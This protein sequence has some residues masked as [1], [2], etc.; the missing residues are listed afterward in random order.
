MNMVYL[1]AWIGLICSA[2]ETPVAKEPT[3]SYGNAQVTA[4][5]RIDES[6][7]LYCDIK[8]FPPII[9]QDMPVKI[10]GLQTSTSVEQNHKIQAFLNLLLLKKTETPQHILLKHLQRG[11]QFC[12]LADIEIDGEDIC[13]LLIDHGLAQRIIAVSAGNTSPQP[14]SP[15]ATRL[16]VERAK[17]HTFVASKTSKIFHRIGC[18]HAKRINSERAVY[19]SSRQEAVQAGRQP[20]KI[21]NP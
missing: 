17:K 7:I 2:S 14:S 16:A 21:C 18:S 19:F 13:D 1:F 8:D 11:D 3:A 20:C 10:N 6:C 4:V 15:Q 12:F 9:G 5:H